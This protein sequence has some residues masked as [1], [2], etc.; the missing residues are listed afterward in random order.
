MQPHVNVNVPHVSVPTAIVVG[1]VGESPWWECNNVCANPPTPPKMLIRHVAV[2]HDHARAERA[3]MVKIRRRGRG[4]C[5]S[6]GAGAGWSCGC[7]SFR[8]ANAVKVRMR[9]ASA[10]GFS[11]PM[12]CWATATGAAVLADMGPNVDRLGCARVLKARRAP[13]DFDCAIIPLLSVFA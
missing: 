13:K 2:D 9:R 7:R 4:G 12:Q 1:V 11:R 6:N 8:G 3:R 5:G 10:G